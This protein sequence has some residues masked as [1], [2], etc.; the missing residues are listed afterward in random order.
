MKAFML[1]LPFLYPELYPAFPLVHTETQLHSVGL[2]PIPSL[3]VAQNL[4][5]SWNCIYA[6]SYRHTL[7]FSRSMSMYI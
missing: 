5:C 1:F 7:K 2:G 6:T 3:A 4:H